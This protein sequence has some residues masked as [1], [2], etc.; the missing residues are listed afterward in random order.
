MVYRENMNAVRIWRL[1]I[2]AIYQDDILLPVAVTGDIDRKSRLPVFH[3]CRHLGSRSKETPP[4]VFILK[5][6]SVLLY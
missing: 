4:S 3:I 5:I 6:K 1:S 2:E